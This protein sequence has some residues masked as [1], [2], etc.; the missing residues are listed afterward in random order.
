M[1][2]N[3]DQSLKRSTTE[4]RAIRIFAIPGL[5][6]DGRIYTRLKN[7]FPEIEILEWLEPL[8][9]ESLEAYAR[10]MANPIESPGGTSLL[11]GTSFG[12][13]VAQEIA[14]FAQLRGLVLI[15]TIKAGDKKPWYYPLAAKMPLYQLVRGKL[16]YRLL[17]YWAPLAGITDPEEQRL[18][19]DMFMN[20]SI[21]HRV[22][23]ADKIVKWEPTRL[24]LPCIHIHGTK[25]QVFGRSLIQNAVFIEGAGHFMVYQQ[26]TEVAEKI[27]NWMN[28]TLKKS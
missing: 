6:V 3:I 28:I 4:R 17:P 16:R 23:G 10:R 9:G 25:D 27:K 20:A 1:R 19:Q 26:A 14:R 22:W 21:R 24:D 13:V 12:G 5:G 11:I 7:H 18:L 15:S 2:S 8:K